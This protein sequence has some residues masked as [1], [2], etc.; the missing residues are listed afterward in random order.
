MEIF[1]NIIKAFRISNLMKILDFKIYSI[2]FYILILFIFISCLMVIL[3]IL[4]INFSSKLY[5]ISESIIHFMIDLICIFLFIPITEIIL[6]PIRCVNGKVYGILNSEN[7]GESMHLLHIIL[8]IIASIFLLIWC[9]FIMSFSFYPFQKNMSTIRINS[10][11]DIIIIFMKLFVVLQHL[12]FTNEYLSLCVLLL[13]SIIMIFCCYNEPTYNN[14]KL[15]IAITIK[16]T[17][18]LWANFVLLISKIFE[19]II[20]RGF[21]FFLI[22][23]IPIVI[24]LSIV[25]YN[26]KNIGSIHFSSN[27]RNLNDYI[28]KAK[29]NIKLINSFIERKINMRDGSENEGRRN[30][31][32]LIGNIKKHNKICTRKEC[33]LTKFMNNEGNYNI[34]KQCLLG[35]MNIFFNNGMR[36]FPNN[37]YLLMLYIHFNFSK[38]YTLNNVRANFLLLKKLNFTIIKKYIIFC[39]EQ[40]LKNNGL[41]FNIENDKDSESKFDIIE[42][43]YKKLKYLIDNSVK[44]Y[45]EFWGIFSLIFLEI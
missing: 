23:G 40:N 21:I 4:F 39:M 44:L 16:N 25:I 37:A 41:E 38:R 17:L 19:N 20:S 9:I 42:Q 3:Q 33:P 14:N 30:L 1:E 5:R 43:K 22:I 45:E 27:N 34:Q 11:N 18:I 13:S 26:E 31:I 35:Y 6:M 15:E 28:K 29:F 32:I 12:L 2:I 8:G 10:R 36:I 24:S 7:C